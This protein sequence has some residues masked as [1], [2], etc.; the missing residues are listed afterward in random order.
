MGQSTAVV[1]VKE[2]P[3]CK[4]GDI[5]FKRGRTEY[6]LRCVSCGSRGPVVKQMN[7][8]WD[9]RTAVADAVDV[10]NARPSE[11]NGEID[12]SE[13]RVESPSKKRE[14]VPETGQPL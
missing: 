6:Q 14:P 1:G 5:T 9:K 7:Y 12:E 4:S 3:F 2:C 8:L 11:K 10:W 13:T